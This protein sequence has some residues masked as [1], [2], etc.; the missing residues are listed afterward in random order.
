MRAS[1]A[2]RGDFQ[3]ARSECPSYPCGTGPAGL[4]SGFPMNRRRNQAVAKQAVK[5]RQLVDPGQCDQRARVGDE[6]RFRAGMR[7]AGL[8]ERLLHPTGH[9]ALDNSPSSSDWG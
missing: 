3:P 7:F 6:R 9:K 1:S 8:P 4:G 5:Q 2:Q